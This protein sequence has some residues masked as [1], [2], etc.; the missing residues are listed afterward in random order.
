MTTRNAIAVRGLRKSYGDHTVSVSVDMTEG[1][2][3][4][5]RTMA[6]ARSWVLTG[7]VIG[8]VI[9]TILSVVLVLGVALLVGFRPQP[10]SS[11]GP[12][13]SV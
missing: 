3:N 2:I 12:R 5:F 11:A 7:H 10:T 9:T 1:I 6:I 4:R 8:G 13:P